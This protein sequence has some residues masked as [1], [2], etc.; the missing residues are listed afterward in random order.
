MHRFSSSPGE[1]VSVAVGVAVR[2]AMSRCNESAR[3]SKHRKPVCER[4]ENE[5]AKLASPE[6]THPSLP[7]CRRSKQTPD[8]H[9]SLLAIS[10]LKAFCQGGH[11]TGTRRFRANLSAHEGRA[12]GRQRS[13]E[14][15]H[16]MLVRGSGPRAGQRK[17]VPSGGHRPL[18]G[19]MGKRKLSSPC[20]LASGAP[21][22]KEE[23]CGCLTLPEMPP[24]P[25]WSR[26]D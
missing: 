2:L 3:R 22:R 7:C 15:S 9:R 26:T 23:F 8:I 11:V 6:A 25:S 4:S 12:R 20:R 14:S 19:G 1:C 13:L 18:A 24:Q 21:F 5:A 17:G 16:T 10:P